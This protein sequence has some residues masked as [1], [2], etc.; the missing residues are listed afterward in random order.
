MRTFI[1]TTVPDLRRFVAEREIGP[2]PTTAHAVTETLRKTYPDEHLEGLEYLA[3]IDAARESLSLL[4]SN[5]AAPSRRVVVA[6]DFPEAAIRSQSESG[7]SSVQIAEAVP[8]DRIASVH[9]DES[10]A[11]PAVRS[12][13]ESIHGTDEV[14]ESAF[15]SVEEHDLLWYARQELPYLL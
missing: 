6:V 13:A 8:F 11:E 5:P 9:L 3:M 12:A 10:A 14:D 2:P 7:E 4:A 15:E 1:G